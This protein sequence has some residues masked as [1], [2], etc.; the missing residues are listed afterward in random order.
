[1]ANTR[2]KKG[3]KTQPKV[4]TANNHQEAVLPALKNQKNILVNETETVNIKQ[5]DTI[6]RTKPNKHS[7]LA[8]SYYSSQLKTT[9]VSIYSNAIN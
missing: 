7:I 9:K 1:M 4:D 8:S 6:S 3:S 2:P 5:M